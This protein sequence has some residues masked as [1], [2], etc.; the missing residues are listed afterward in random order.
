MTTERAGGASAG[1][2]ATHLTG[3]A[4]GW[5]TAFLCMKLIHG[6]LSPVVIAAIRATGAAAALAAAVIAI[7]QSIIPKER[8]WRDWL[9]LGTLNGWGP[10]IL[11]AYA[12]TRMD[13]GPAA[14]I[15]AFTPLLTAMLAQAFLPAERVTGARAFGILIGLGG[16]ALLV[17]PKALEGGAT[18][19]GVLA[20]LLLTFGY[21]LG[22]IYA[23]VIP[24]PVPIR[25]AL[26]QQ[27]VSGIVALLLALATVGVA[28]FEGAAQHSGALATLAIFSTAMPI[29]LFMRLITRAGSAP[30]SMTGY[31]IPTVAVIVG[32]VVLGEPIVPRQIL[33]GAIVLVGVA[34]VS[35]ALR[36][37]LRRPA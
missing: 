11:V 2:I 24:D 29:F 10:N 26:G 30:A 36:L 21:A 22:N 14:L 34:I 9:L 37:P 13:S 28:G 7:G 27:S 12:L 16:M 20:M 8:E 18:L 3:C 33:G 4:I 6:E 15:Q 23:R 5:G 35:G 1:F 31:L 19:E 25:L 32:V 17:G